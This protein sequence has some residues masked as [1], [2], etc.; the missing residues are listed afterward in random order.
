MEQKALTKCL[1]CNKLL[2]AM[3]APTDDEFDATSPTAGR[4]L[5]KSGMSLTQVSGTRLMTRTVG[6]K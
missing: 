6:L 1:P 2:Q 5:R 4:R 3:Q